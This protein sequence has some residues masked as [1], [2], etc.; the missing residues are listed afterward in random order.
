M[1]RLF[2]AFEGVST[3]YL[4]RSGELPEASATRTARCP[5]MKLFRARLFPI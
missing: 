1:D 3:I 2:K 5:N 4:G